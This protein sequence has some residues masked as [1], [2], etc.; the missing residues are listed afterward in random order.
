MGNNY[1][2]EQKQYPRRMAPRIGRVFGWAVIGLIFVCLFALIF[3]FV[4]KWLW[5]VLMPAV[6]GLG[7]IS[8]WQAVA[9][10]I[11]AKLLF[12]GFGHPH[13]RDP[14]SWH[15]WGRYTDWH[16]S[17]DRY[18]EK[19]ES[20]KNRFRDW[21][22]YRRFWEDEGKDAFRAYVDRQ[23]ITDDDVQNM[24]SEGDERGKTDI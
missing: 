5:N 17:W 16:R 21:K 18:G 2:Y 9:L 11:L 19:R 7:A 20:M 15:N 6:F 3:G 12:G 22:A 8:F 10:V 24:K 23:N 4:V 14:K 13:Q 1:Q